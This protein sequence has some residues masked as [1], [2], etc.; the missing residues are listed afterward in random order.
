MF[1]LDYFCFYSCFFFISFSYG[2]FLFRLLLTFSLFTFLP[3]FLRKNVFALFSLLNTKYLL[4]HYQNHTWS[5][6]ASLQNWKDQL[7]CF[8]LAFLL[9]ACLHHNS[10]RL[11]FFLLLLCG[12]FAASYFLF[13]LSF[14][15]LVKPR[16]FFSF[17]NQLAIKTKQQISV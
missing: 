12:S 9:F 7:N 14:L 17:T 15:F 8:W 13:L 4:E 1:I 3:C 10:H 5:L 6:F 16:L 2:I 11:L